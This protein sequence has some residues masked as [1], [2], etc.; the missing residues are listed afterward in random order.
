MYLQLGSLMCLIGI[1]T[2]AASVPPTVTHPI[3]GVGGIGE[4][5]SVWVLCQMNN[6]IG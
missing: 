1:T 5:A 3:K 2:K 6:A 4:N